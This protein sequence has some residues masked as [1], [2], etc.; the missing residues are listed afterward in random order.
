M[1]LPSYFLTLNFLRA[2][3]MM[4][5]LAVATAAQGTADLPAGS[6]KGSLM[7][8][9]ATADLKFAAAFVDQK[10]ESKR[11]VLVIRNQKLPVEKWESKFDMMKDHTK[12]S[13]VVFFLD[14][15]GKF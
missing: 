11:I 2:A 6:A 12:W 15:E 8:D 1:I 3:S 13:G 7:Y 10:D 14:K 5:I 4:S 9:G